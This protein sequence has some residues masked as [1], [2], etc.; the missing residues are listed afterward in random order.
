MAELS[1]EHS[2]FLLNESSFS[3]MFTVIKDATGAIN[4]VFLG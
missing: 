3:K 2:V 4:H 1:D